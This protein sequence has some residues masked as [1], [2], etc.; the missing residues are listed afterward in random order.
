MDVLDH[1]P[2]VFLL[3]PA[4]A[5]GRRALQL[6]APRASFA[7]AGRLRSPE[8]LPIGEA[9]CFMSALY[10]RG[11]LA[12]ARRFASSWAGPPVL[13]ECAGQESRV[14]LQ[15]VPDAGSI[16]IIAPGFGLVTPEWP[17]T[18]ERLRRLARTP[19]DPARRCY[20][21][22][23]RRHARELV[24]RVPAGARI[25]L[26]GSI[27]TG[28]YLDLLL[29]ILGERLLFPRAFTGTGDMRRG[30]MMLR[31]AASGEELDYAAAAR[32]RVP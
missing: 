27:A 13:P 18:A 32:P 28:K 5:T 21:A 25:V 2:K 15:P 30:A 20:S 10:F 16:L 19:V 14:E 22:P 9:F 1:A 4:I 6:A 7:A 8:G 23:L 11:K 29:P 12:Y 31:A 26:L 24:A 3:S 17:L